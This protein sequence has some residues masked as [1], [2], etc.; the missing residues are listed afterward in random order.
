M[1][2]PPIEKRLQCAPQSAVQITRRVYA[3]TGRLLWVSLNVR[4]LRFNGEA[5]VIA[6]LTDITARRSA[7][8]ELVKFKLGIDRAYFSVMIT[9]VDGVIRY[10]NP[11]FT[12]I[13]GYT[14][15]EAMGRDPN[16]L[17]SGSS[18][19]NISAFGVNC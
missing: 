9:D 14:A 19:K 15:E 4:P 6:N 1:L 10:V 7:E 18:P 17:K 16:L 3:I 8:N 2:I 12:K 11:A 13:Y 5:C